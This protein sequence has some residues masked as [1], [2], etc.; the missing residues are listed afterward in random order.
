M[1]RVLLIEDIEDNAQLVDRVLTANGYEVLHAPDGETGLQ[2]ATDKHPDLI[3]LDLGLPDI[4]GQTVASQLR[5]DPEMARTPILVVT[6][7]PEETA[8]QMIKAYGCNGYIS[9]PVKIATLLE[10]VASHLRQARP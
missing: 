1:P 10:Q 6:A 5:R 4:D 8:R 7:W 9:K 3:L 2:M